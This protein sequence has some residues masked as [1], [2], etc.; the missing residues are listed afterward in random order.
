MESIYPKN[1]IERLKGLTLTEGQY[2]GIRAD[3]FLTMNNAS[4][5]AIVNAKF[6]TSS[7]DLDKDDEEQKFYKYLDVKTNLSKEKRMILQFAAPFNFKKVHSRLYDSRRRLIDEE[8]YVSDFSVIDESIT[9]LIELSEETRGFLE[10]IPD[11]KLIGAASALTYFFFPA[12]QKTVFTF[13]PERE[14]W[15]FENQQIPELVELANQQLSQGFPTVYDLY[16]DP[17][18]LEV[19][20]I[21]VETLSTTKLLGVEVL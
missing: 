12:D 3:G 6:S 2:E 7:R 5:F 16:L 13:Y 8:Y 10:N 11:E 9:R 21:P 14:E 4:Q 19:K 20:L 15:V 18:T 1:F 17:E